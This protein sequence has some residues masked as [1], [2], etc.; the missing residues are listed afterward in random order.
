M[1]PMDTKQL[2]EKIERE[3][4][5]LRAGDKSAI[6]RIVEA[7]NQRQIERRGHP[8]YLVKGWDIVAI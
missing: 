6:D 4:A 3:L 8:G 1:R 2:A 5:Q 7:Y